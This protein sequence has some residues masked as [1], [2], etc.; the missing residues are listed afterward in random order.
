MLRL[1]RASFLSF[2]NGPRR[3]LAARRNTMRNTPK[4]ENVCCDMVRQDVVT[5]QKW[6][7][8][9]DL[10]MRLGWQI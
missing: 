1:L 2:S 3:H 4:N 10:C 8:H 6:Q 7:L 5:A 9:P